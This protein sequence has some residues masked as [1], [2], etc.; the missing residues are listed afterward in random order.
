MVELVDIGKSDSEFDSDGDG[1][2][3]RNSDNDG[4]G[5]RNSDNDGG[6]DISDGNIVSTDAD[7]E[8][9]SVDVI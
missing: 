8:Q 4:D 6:G 2:G 1:E 3:L 7:S 9:S 5:D